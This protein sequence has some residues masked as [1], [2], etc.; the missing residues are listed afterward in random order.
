MINSLSFV[1]NRNDSYE[2]NEINKY[3]LEKN[4]TMEKIFME[5][6]D[7]SEHIISIFKFHYSIFWSHLFTFLPFKSKFLSQLFIHLHPQ[8]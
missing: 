6:C 2:I 3:L 5:K 4:S 7:K 8:I 1:K